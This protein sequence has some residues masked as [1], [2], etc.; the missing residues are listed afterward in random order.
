[1]VDKLGKLVAYFLQDQTSSVAGQRM[2]GF[3]A[4]L[5]TCTR[6]AMAMIQL[7]LHRLPLAKMLLLNLQTDI[8]KS[9]K[10]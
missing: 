2:H 7:V 6:C 9:F 3:W 8:T 10:N 1:M 5:L 4:S